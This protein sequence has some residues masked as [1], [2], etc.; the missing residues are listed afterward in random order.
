MGR[1]R[2]LGIGYRERTDGRIERRW[3]DANGNRHSVIAKTLE[4]CEQKFNERKDEIEAGSYRK[5]EKMT[6]D[7]L[8]KEFVQI[9]TPNV[10]EA[11]I[12]GW[13]KKYNRITAIIPADTKV[14][15]IEPRM[16]EQ[17]QVKM[18][19]G[20]ERKAHRPNGKEYVANGSLSTATINNTITFLKAML[21]RAVYNG[22]LER[23]PAGMIKSLRRQ[24]DEA[25]AVDTTHKALTKEE[26]DALFSKAKEENLYYEPFFEFLLRTGMRC[27]EAAA[28]TLADIDR[29]N[30][31][32]HIRRTVTTDKNGSPVIGDSP[33]TGESRDID[34]DDA[35]LDCLKRQHQMHEMVFGKL[36]TETIF[37]TTT[38]TLIQPPIVNQSLTRLC[39]RAGVET[40]TIHCFRDSF[41][42][43]SLQAGASPQ[44]VAAH[45]G[46]RSLKMLLTLYGQ[47]QD[48]WKRDEMSKLKI[49]V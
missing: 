27:G 31:I 45:L 1:K 20:Y 23:N 39:K 26:M 36:A 46:H 30:H 13:Q 42:T 6:L 40:R 14:R 7:D 16:I 19:S 18:L 12:L 9:N 4:E 41:A 28:L 10:K 43:L 17:M 5:N 34:I 8:Y 15:S 32:I 2:A 35:V 47:V 24:K 21:E 37:T 22:V 33:K 25:E 38:G 44:A 49:S 29:K 48:S 3:T 11:T